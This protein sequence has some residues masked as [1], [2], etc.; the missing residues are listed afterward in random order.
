MEKKIEVPDCTTGFGYFIISQSGRSLPVYQCEWHWAR[1][2]LK[3]ETIGSAPDE[4]TAMNM[5][6]AYSGGKKLL[7]R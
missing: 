2:W 6:R 3:R 4:P 1:G 5:I 7:I